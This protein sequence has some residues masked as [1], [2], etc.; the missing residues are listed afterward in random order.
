MWLS[1]TMSENDM[2]EIR[3]LLLEQ[4]VKIEALTLEVRRLRMAS[5]QTE[6]LYVAE[7][8]DLEDHY[9][10]TDAAALD[11]LAGMKGNAPNT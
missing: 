7:P 5:E 10:A 6:V 8:V 11:I 4:G 9:S 3:R 2:R 1:R